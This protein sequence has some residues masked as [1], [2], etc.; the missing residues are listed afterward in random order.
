MRRFSSSIVASGRAASSTLV[1]SAVLGQGRLAATY[2][3]KKRNA[4]TEVAEYFE[5]EVELLSGDDEAKG[6]QEELKKRL[7]DW[8]KRF[9]FHVN[10]GKTEIV[11]TKKDAALNA[12]V[13]V[14]IDPNVEETDNYE[15]EGEDE[16]AEEDEEEGEE[17]E[18]EPESFGNVHFTVEVK[19][20]DSTLVAYGIVSEAAVQVTDV[21]LQDAEGTERSVYDTQRLDDEG[22][23]KIRLYLSSLGVNDSFVGAAYAAAHLH[24]EQAYHTWVHDVLAFT[25]Q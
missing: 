25:K 8:A 1:R 15:D 24:D 23:E 6:Q 7:D 9:H 22:Q 13:T 16:K 11:A 20:A 21:A 10:M 19:K 12:D 17:E 4:E 3:T 5:K 14:K 18:E 2:A